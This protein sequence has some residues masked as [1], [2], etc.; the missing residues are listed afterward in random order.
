MKRTIRLEGWDYV[1]PAAVTFTDAARREVGR[2][3][4]G[5]PGKIVAIGWGKSVQVREQDGTLVEELGDLLI[6]GLG[7]AEESDPAVTVTLDGEAIE[8][9][10]PADVTRADAPV[11]DVGANGRLILRE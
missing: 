9:A 5:F 6:V 7:T 8:I 10:L 4:A 2:L 1:H 3:R 11:I